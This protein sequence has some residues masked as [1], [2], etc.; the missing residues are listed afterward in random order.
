M[1]LAVLT[2]TFNGAQPLDGDLPYVD[3]SG[4]TYSAA[5][6]YGIGLSVAQTDIAS[7]LIT[8]AVK[9]TSKT[10]SGFRVCVSDQFTGTVEI[11]LWD[12]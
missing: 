9:G 4:L 8:A 2:A 5:S 10:A 3:I 12:R 1:A 6:A 11:E 7:G